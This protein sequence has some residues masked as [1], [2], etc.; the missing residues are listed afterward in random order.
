MLT[1]LSPYPVK[2]VTFDVILYYFILLVFSGKVTTE[3]RCGGKYFDRIVCNSFWI[4]QV[5]EG[6]KSMYN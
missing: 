3:F 2:L 4:T 6:L 1:L 5:K